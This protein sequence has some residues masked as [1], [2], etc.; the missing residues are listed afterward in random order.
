M[1]MCWHAG[2]LWLG[3]KTGLLLSI[4][5]HSHERPAILSLPKEESILSVVATAQVWALSQSFLMHVLAETK[6]FRVFDLNQAQGPGVCLTKNLDNLWLLQCSNVTSVSVYHSVEVVARSFTVPGLVMAASSVGH[7][8]GLATEKEILVYTNGEAKAITRQKSGRVVDL[9]LTEEIVYVAGLNEVQ[10]FNL[11][12]ELLQQ[13]NCE[14]NIRCIAADWVG[15]TAGLFSLSPL[16]HLAGKGEIN[17][18]LLAGGCLWAADN[19]SKTVSCYS[20]E[21]N[22]RMPSPGQRRRHNS[23]PE[24]AAAPTLSAPGRVLAK[25]RATRHGLLTQFTSTVGLQ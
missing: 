6:Q 5:D 16:Q 18:L 15:T 7:R 20:F 1:A 23:E 17:C 12:G 2:S 25:R 21:A 19:S 4:A 24:P 14:P 9:L 11:E 22:F 3:L 10:S 13:L 8:V